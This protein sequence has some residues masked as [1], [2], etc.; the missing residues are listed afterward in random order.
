MIQIFD[1]VLSEKD[2]N[3][4]QSLIT[5]DIF[6]WY[7]NR[8]EYILDLY[9]DNCLSHSQFTHV[10]Y[11]E[12]IFGSSKKAIRSPYYSTF[13]PYIQHFIKHYKVSGSLYRMKLNC[14][15]QDNR[16]VDKYNPIHFDEDTPHSSLLYYINESDGDTIFFNNGKEIQRVSPKKNRLVISNGPIAHCSSNPIKTEL[17]YVLNTVILDK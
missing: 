9:K 12:E 14:Q 4:I 13:F 1:N 10:L 2:N 8:E 15:Y 17:R 3:N 7:I 6:P 11:N 5:K 16:F